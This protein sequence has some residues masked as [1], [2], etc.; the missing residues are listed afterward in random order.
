M[1]KTNLLIIRIHFQAAMQTITRLQPLNYEDFQI[2]ISVEKSWKQDV[3]MSSWALRN[4]DVK[5]SLYLVILQRK[6]MLKNNS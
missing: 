1:I 2:F 3:N 6:Q 4:C 5:L